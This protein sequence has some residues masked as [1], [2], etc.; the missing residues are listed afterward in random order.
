MWMQHNMA[1]TVEKASREQE[2]GLSIVQEGLLLQNE[3][4]VPQ[5]LL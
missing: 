1:V 2:C 4:S 5:V 3:S